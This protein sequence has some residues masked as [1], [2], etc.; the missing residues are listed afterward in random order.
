M[1]GKNTVEA[2]QSGALYGFA[3]QVD[4]LVDRILTELG[5]KVTA[6]IATGG[7]A[8][9][10]VAESRTLTHPPPALPPLALE[11]I[12]AYEVD[13]GVGLGRGYRRIPHRE[14]DGDDDIVAVVNELRHVVSVVLRILG[15]DVLD[16]VI[17]DT[18][19]LGRL[20]CAFPGRLVEAA[21]ID[22][23]DISHQTDLERFGA[24]CLGIAG[25]DFTAVQVRLEL[26]QLVLQV[27]GQLGIEIMESSQTRT[28]EVVAA[29]ELGILRRLDQI[30]HTRGCLL[31]TSDA[32]DDLLCVDL[33]GRR[34]IKKKNITTQ[35]SNNTLVS[36]T[37]IVL[38]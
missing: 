24:G 29:R 35:N 3:G 12:H 13:L 8:P 37:I 30:H 5:G 4:G 21:V 9:I 18:Q 27:F 38:H 26:G 7:L 33:G 6:V 17:G 11:L 25:L 34:I 28:A 22:A 14:T 19:F 36:K 31:Y 20:L 32:A 2:L 16:I 1:I 15:L 10:V 23:T